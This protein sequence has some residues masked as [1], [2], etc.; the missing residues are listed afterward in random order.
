MHDMSGLSLFEIIS[1][2]FLGALTL[3]HIGRQIKAKVNKPPLGKIPE[4]TCPHCA[5]GEKKS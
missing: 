4:A 2:A 3:Y 5:A 1:G